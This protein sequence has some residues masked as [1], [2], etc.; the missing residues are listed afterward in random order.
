MAQH[1][2]L[3]VLDLGGPAAANQQLQQRDEDEVDE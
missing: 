2:Q 3:E 1:D